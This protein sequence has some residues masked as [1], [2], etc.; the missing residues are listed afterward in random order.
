LH[1]RLESFVAPF[2]A[3][4][5]THGA[6]ALLLY[7]SPLDSLL[8]RGLLTDGRFILFS[9]FD[10]VSK[11]EVRSFFRLTGGRIKRKPTLPKVKR[12]DVWLARLRC[13][14]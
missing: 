6:T 8:L 13:F 7:F 11:G 4:G 3:H 5:W 12:G 14:Y 1:S 2:L 9:V 10:R